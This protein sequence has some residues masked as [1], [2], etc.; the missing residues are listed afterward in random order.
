MSVGRAEKSWGVLLLIVATVTVCGRSEFVKRQTIK[1]GLW[2]GAFESRTDQIT[3]QCRRVFLFY[4]RELS[5]ESCGWVLLEE[6]RRDVESPERVLGA[7]DS[8]GGAKREGGGGGRARALG[9]VFF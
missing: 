1:E 7:E 3:A 4:A 6:R 8:D 2:A 5:A 9:Y